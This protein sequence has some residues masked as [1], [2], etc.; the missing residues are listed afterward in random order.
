MTRDVEGLAELRRL[1]G[2]IVTRAEL[3]ALGYTASAVRA[4]LDAGRWQQ[5][6]PR[7]FALHTG[8]LTWITRAW[9]ALAYAGP[10]AVLSH[11][12]AAYARGWTKEP[13]GPI[14][15]TVPYNRV[16]RP[17]PGIR[18]HR[19]RSYLHIVARDSV[20]PCTT[21]ARTVADVLR[22]CETEQEAT[23]FVLECIRTRR[24]SAESI[25][26]E[27]LAE[28]RHPWRQ[29]AL[30]ATGA[31]VR[32]NQSLLEGMWSRIEEAHGLPA[33]DRQ[34]RVVRDGAAQ[35]QDVRYHAYAAVVE[36]DGRIGH[37]DTEGRLRDMRRDNANTIAG[38]ATL[39]FGFY[40]LTHRGCEGA[41]QLAALLRR[42]GWRGTFVRCPSCGESTEAAS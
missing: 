32:G 28:R 19:S 16:V 7:V 1:R 38:L 11:G 18:T 13:G 20:L 29:A 41:A 26:P 15:V 31:A 35:F 5:V 39:R 23:A 2:A 36:L 34:V 24:V 8:P 6:H 25:A 42:N 37:E 40:D 4:Q 17:Q 12:S 22:S 33:G 27:L 10:G 9:A 3:Q 30:D 14:H 21:A